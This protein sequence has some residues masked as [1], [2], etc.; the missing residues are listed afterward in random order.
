MASGKTKPTALSVKKFIQAIEH[1]QRREDAFTI[2][3]MMENISQLKP[4]MW[5]PSIIGFGQYHYKYDSGREGDS[6]M[7][8][9]SP[10]KQKQVLYVLY[11]FHKQAQLLVELGKHKTGKV[12]LYINKLTDIDI[13]V[14]ETIIQAAWKHVNEK[15]DMKG[16]A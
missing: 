6:P 7:L 4:K 5:G 16:C 14:L 1:E 12:C 10:R 9:F 3:K 8:A 15:E 2:L 13:K 11:G